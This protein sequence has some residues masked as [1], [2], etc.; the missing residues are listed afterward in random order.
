LLSSY[1]ARML[2]EAASPEERAQ[3][4]VAKERAAVSKHRGRPNRM[5]EENEVRRRPGSVL[6][7]NF[8]F[9]ALVMSGG[10]YLY[11]LL[12]ADWSYYSGTTRAKIAPADPAQPPLP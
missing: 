11:I 1:S 9:G 4:R 7:A 10:A 6:C 12:C 8:G 3:A 5:P 2:K